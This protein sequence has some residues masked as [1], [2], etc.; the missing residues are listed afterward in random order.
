MSIVAL[1]VTLCVIILMLWLVQTFMPLPWKTPVLV[2]VVLL[3]LLWL[4]TLL[5]PSL[6]AFRVGR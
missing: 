6:S 4:I 5:F 1:V 3:A 2:I